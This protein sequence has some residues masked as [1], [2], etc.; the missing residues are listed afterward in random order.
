MERFAKL[1]KCKA[2]IILLFSSLAVNLMAIGFISNITFGEIFAFFLFQCFAIFGIGLMIV[3][4]LDLPLCSDIQVFVF[5]YGVG[6]VIQIINYYIL[7]PLKQSDMF[8]VLLATETIVLF[9]LCLSKKSEGLKEMEVNLQETYVCVGFVICT[10]LIRFF[11][12][13]GKGLIPHGEYINIY[14]HINDVY[15]WMENTVGAKYSFPIDDVKWLD[16]RLHYHYF[17][18][19]YYAVMSRVTGISIAK[20]ELQIGY[21]QPT[22]MLVMSVYSLFEIFKTRL[23]L[24]IIGMMSVFL[25]SGFEYVAIATW[26][27]HLYVVSLGFDVGVAFCVLIFVL[28]II[29]YRS[30]NFLWSTYVVAMIFMA[31]TTGIK[32]PCA[33]LLLCGLATIC[34]TWLLS[35]QYNKTFF[36]GLG[37]LIA[38]AV[39][40]LFIVTD[41]KQTL[42]IGLLEEFMASIMHYPIAS[43]YRRL[44]EWGFPQ[45]IA[46]ILFLGIWLFEVQ[47]CIFLMCLMAMGCYFFFPGVRQ[48]TW[49]D[50]RFF[51]PVVVILGILWTL[52][53]KQIG[54]SEMYFIM[55]TF[56]FAVAFACQCFD[57]MWDKKGFR[58][59]CYIFLAGAICFGV[60]KAIENTAQFWSEGMNNLF[61]VNGV[62]ADID[63]PRTIR[64]EEYEAYEWIRE[65]TTYED[66]LL[67]NL[68]LLKSNEDNVMTSAFTERRLWYDSHWYLSGYQAQI[69]QEEIEKKETV[70]QEFYDGDQATIKELQKDG[71][72]YVIDIKEISPLFTLASDIAEI[73]FENNAVRVYHFIK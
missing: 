48:E 63:T 69:T 27:G 34:L 33:L 56:P 17:S 40:Y 9:F 18:S 26:T 3:Y 15:C 72:T 32:G 30:E 7:M 14:P 73:V 52:F 29:Q 35:G 22:I 12:S 37:G 55:M 41:V 2:I 4:L 8:L 24:R 23:S 19:I 49:R 25:T 67:T 58:Y 68:Y 20:I 5:A 31:V 57:K 59:S 21:F 66:I 36:Y 13:F 39:V 42:R 51:L 6:Y 1:R 10:L 54:G 64:I 62:E 47:P 61:K 45:W 44:C 46:G 60:H 16:T 71:V 50:G 43:K 28:L 53:V 11:M 65:N 38:F 70:V